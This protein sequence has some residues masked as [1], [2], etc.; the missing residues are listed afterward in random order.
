MTL[1]WNL[2][3]KEVAYLV[4]AL[5]VIP[6]ANSKALRLF[7]EGRVTNPEYPIRPL[8]EK[9]FFYPPMFYNTTVNANLKRAGARRLL[10]PFLFHGIKGGIQIVDNG[11]SIPADGIEVLVYGVKFILK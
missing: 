8:P 5:G 1:S 11:T 9:L 7:V 10:K 3:N 6:H 4:S 2:V